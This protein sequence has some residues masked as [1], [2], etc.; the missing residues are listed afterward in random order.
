MLRINE[1]KKTVVFFIKNLGETNFLDSSK[2]RH[3]ESSP[4][5]ARALI[6]ANIPDGDTVTAVVFSED[7][8]DLVSQSRW[9]LD[10]AMDLYCLENETRIT[11][12]EVLDEVLDYRP[13][14]NSCINRHTINKGWSKRI[15]NSPGQMYEFRKYNQAILS[16]LHARNKAPQL[17]RSIGQ[18]VRLF[19]MANEAVDH[20]TSFVFHY[21][22]LEV[23]ISGGSLYQKKTKFS[24][25]LQAIHPIKNRP[26]IL[27]TA[28][29]IYRARGDLLHAGIFFDGINNRRSEKPLQ[30]YI[31]QTRHFYLNCLDAL[32][33][34]AYNEK[35]IEKAW[36]KLGSKEHMYSIR[37]DKNTAVSYRR[38]TAVRFLKHAEALNRLHILTSKATLPSPSESP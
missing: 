37:P 1:D 23:L 12:P 3:V 8:D 20:V 21:C 33:K 19:R 17:R 18:S 28:N 35:T 7:I 16:C 4:A 11:R 26:F 38:W 32:L 36:A 22:A 15:K 10:R 9:K 2:F 14:G 13:V 27:K 31:K 30:E 5:V 25:R 6:E 24:E 29:G 34:H